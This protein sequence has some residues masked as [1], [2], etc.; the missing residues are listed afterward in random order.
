MSKKFN[1]NNSIN[2]NNNNNNDDEDVK[3][4]IH[5][6]RYISPEKRKQIIDELRLVPKTYVW[7][8]MY[9][10]QRKITNYW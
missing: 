2:N 1:K 10:F 5:L 6:K 7:M 4:T 3:L 9:I 8:S